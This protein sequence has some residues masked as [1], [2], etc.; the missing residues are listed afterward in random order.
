MKQLIVLPLIALL[1]LAGCGGTNIDLQVPAQAT[2]HQVASFSIA[3][4]DTQVAQDEQYQTMSTYLNNTV[5]NTLAGKG[6]LS[7]VQIIISVKRVDIDMSSRTLAN[8]VF[9]G[10]LYT[11]DTDVQVVDSQTHQLLASFPLRAMAPRKSYRVWDAD[12][13]SQEAM[14]RDKFDVL[15]QTY[16]NTLASA[17]Y[18]R[19]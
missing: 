17:L 2:N 5:P 14:R 1:S 8:S 16:A 10:P 15:S 18:P 19:N 7:P 6:T 12:A 13:Y 11:M 9:V 3:P 4:A